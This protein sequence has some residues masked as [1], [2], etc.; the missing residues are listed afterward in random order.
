MHDNY[1]Q[2]NSPLGTLSIA[3]FSHE[4]LQEII[5]NCLENYRVPEITDGYSACI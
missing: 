1:H 3:Q 4:L 5:F 2:L